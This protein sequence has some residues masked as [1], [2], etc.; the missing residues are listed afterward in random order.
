MSGRYHCYDQITLIFLNCLSVVILCATQHLCFQCSDP[1]IEVHYGAFFN[2]PRILQ[3]S[4]S[5]NERQPKCESGRKARIQ[6]CRDPCYTLNVTTFDIKTEQF[7]LFGMS[8]GC[9]TLI[10]PP[11]KIRSSGC[12]QSN[13]LLKTTPAHPLQTQYCFCTSD[14]CNIIRPANA[15]MHVDASRFKEQEI[16]PVVIHDYTVPNIISG[17]ITKSVHLSDTFLLLFVLIR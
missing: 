6:I 8:H 17:S 13:I 5:E 4:S 1:N 10:L 12:Y 9:S 15:M 16:K 14:S 11:S 2:N 3:D 7:L